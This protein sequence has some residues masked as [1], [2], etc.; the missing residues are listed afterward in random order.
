MFNI[1][2]FSKVVGLTVKTLRFYH[3]QELLVPSYIDPQTGY[4]QYDPSQIETA[5]TIARLR[6]LE[7]S[8]SDI[9]EILQHQ[10]GGDILEIIVRQRA[11]LEGKIKHLR[12]ARRVLDQFIAQERQAMIVQQANGE[13]REKT[14]DPILI[15]A[16]RTKGRYSDCGKA[17]GI[18]GR[19]FGRQIA[20]HPLLLHYDNEYKEEDADFEACM[21]IRQSKTIDGVS[22]RQLPGGRCVAL[23]HK[24]PYDQLGRSYAR[25]LTYIKQ[26][27]YRIVVPTR[28]VYLKGPGMI[29]KGNPR[30][31]LTEIEMLIE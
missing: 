20:G 15:A 24:G 22:V 21:P 2:E 1:G 6:G 12:Q 7:F 5:R 16:I 14:V 3:E 31:Y 27:G 28:E 17:F 9:K 25:I 26:K 29:F 13:L 4:R 18:L 19:S 23:I 10:G 11:I 8:L 30:N